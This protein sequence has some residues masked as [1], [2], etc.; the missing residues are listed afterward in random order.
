MER[1][2]IGHCAD[3]GSCEEFGRAKKIQVGN[4]TSKYIFE[5]LLGQIDRRK[6]DQC[7]F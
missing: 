6:P 5:Q 2:G 4:E 3:W 7:V 1:A